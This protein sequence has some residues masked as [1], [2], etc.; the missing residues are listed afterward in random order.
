MLYFASL[1]F[2]V[3]RLFTSLLDC[4]VFR[5][6]DKPTEIKESK[7]DQNIVFLNNVCRAEAIT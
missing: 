2:I 5:L 4:Y 6:E 7:R 1:Y 3:R